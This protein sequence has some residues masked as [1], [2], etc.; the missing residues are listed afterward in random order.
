MAIDFDLTLVSLHLHNDQRIEVADLAKFIRPFFLEFVPLA[1]HSNILI[2]IVTFS[3][4]VDMI[5]SLLRYSFGDEIAD[6]IVIRGC[7]ETW[8]YV[9]KLQYLGRLLQ[10][11]ASS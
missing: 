5:S 4:L 10:A 2:A 3:K 8:E 9:G 6:S 7:D 11:L 1:V